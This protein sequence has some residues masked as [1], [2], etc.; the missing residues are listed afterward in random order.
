MRN[1]IIN[2]DGYGFTAGTTRAIEECVDFGTVR[3]LSVNINYPSAE[4]LPQLLKTHPGLSVGCH[5]NPVVGRP[6]LPVE[7]VSTLVNENGEFF[8]REF[9]R[10]FLAGKIKLEHLRA[11]MLAQVEKTRSFAGEALS[12]IDFHMGLHRLPGLY[13]IFLDVAEKSDV[14]RI[15]T[16]KYLVG[17][18]HRFPRFRHFGFMFESAMRIPKFI[19]I[20]WLRKIAL[21]RGLAM[22]DLW[23]GISHMDEKGLTIE[24]YLRMLTNIPHGF[25]EFVVH[26]GYIDNDLLQCS[27]YL[28]PRVRER[29]IL[30]HPAFREALFSSDI[31]LAG[32]RDIPLRVLSGRPLSALISPTK[33]SHSTRP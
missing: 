18:E 17:L 30:L 1:L 10:R 14:G 23:V 6:V 24:N 5:I 29:E 28:A 25:S 31:R 22:P 4:R 8:Y 7:K 27:T 3:S 21:K 15:R 20:L 11:E 33:K 12:H 9:S 16:H 13:K 26:P 32:Y 2:A 19:W